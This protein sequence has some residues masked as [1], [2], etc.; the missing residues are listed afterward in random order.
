MQSSPISIAMTIVAPR[1]I[2]STDSLE[3]FRQLMECEKKPYK[4][5]SKSVLAIGGMPD[6][7]TI[8]A[9]VTSVKSER[10]NDSL[11]DRSTTQ[12]RLEETRI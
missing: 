8:S 6:G 2:V 10:A 1:S 9:A 4:K 3:S 5:P 12:I 11:A 7:P